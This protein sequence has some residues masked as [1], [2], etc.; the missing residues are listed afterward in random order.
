MTEKLTLAEK[1]W[2]DHVVRKGEN[3]EPDLL[4][5]DFQLLHEVTSPQAFDG[6]RLAGRTMR[7]PELHLATED[8][9]VPTVGIKTG[10]LLEIKDEVS[11]TQVSTL[12]KNCEEFGVRLHSMGDAQQ[13]IVHTVGPQLGITQP[14][15]TIVCG[16]SHTSTHGAFGSIAM[17]IGTS[18]VEHVMATQTLS[19]KPFKTMAIEVSGELA[20]GVSAKDLILAIIAKIGTGGGQGHIIEYRGEAIRKMSMEARMTICNM[21]IEAGARAGMVAPDETTFEYVKG[22]EFAPQGEDWDAAVEYWKTLPTDEGAEFDT[23][24]EIDG[25]ALTPFV[26]WGTNPGQGLPLSATVPDPEECGDDGE[27]ASVEKA[28]SYMDLKPGTPL[29][30]IQIDTVFLGSCTNARIEDLRAAAEVVKGRSIAADTRMMV[31]PSS[32]VVKAQAEEEGLDKIF[33]DFGAEWRTAGCSMCLGM[34][35]DQLK[36]G[37]RSASTSNRNF[38]GRQGPGG[39][40]H[41]VS[42]AVAA[43]TAVLGHLAAPADIDDSAVAGA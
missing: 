19:L 34:N 23:V 10:N 31:V 22:R 36:P 16:D 21:S 26:T 3:G 1:V 9:N 28:L 12:R 30:D 20:E 43:A 17:G 33:T 32:A 40:T 11:R 35:P 42:P 29:R 5:I 25:S 13:G 6:L 4:Y 8:H 41:L 37:E 7:H 18:E 38:E 24:V 15:M 2:R 27:K 39:R 14:G